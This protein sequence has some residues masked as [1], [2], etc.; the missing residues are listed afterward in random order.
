[1]T[2]CEISDNDLRRRREKGEEIRDRA[3]RNDVPNKEICHKNNNE[4]NE[5]SNYIASYSKALPHFDINNAR[6]G[7]VNEN[8]YKKLLKAT[9]S[10][11]PDDFE[12]VPLGGSVKLTNPLSG[13]AFDLQGIDCHFLDPEIV[14][15]APKIN[16]AEAAGEMAELY[17]M[18]LCRD[19]HFNDFDTSPLISDAITDL[20]NNNNYSKF[21]VAPYP[22][23][24][25]NIN[26]KSIFRGFT[27]G[28]V[29]GPFVSQFLLKG[30]NDIDRLLS[31]GSIEYVQKEDEGF[32]KYGSL[33]IDQRQWTVIP[34][35][36]YLTNY[37]DFLNSQ[38]GIKPPRSETDSC[39]N[40]YDIQARRF[41]RNMRDMANYVHFDDL[42]Q[43]FLNACLLLLHMEVPCNNPQMTFDNDNPYG[44]YRK[45]VGFGT[46][47]PPHFLTIVAEVTTRA[48][49]VCWFYKW[50]IHRRLRAEALGGLIHRQLN[51]QVSPPP[52]PPNTYDIHPEILNKTGA[53]QILKRI[54]D[55][56]GSYLLPQA[57]PEGAPTHPSYAAGH[58][59]IAGACVTILK[60]FFDGGF[61]I[62]NPV[63]SNSDGTS[64]IDYTGSDKNDLTVEGELN[65][66]ASNI[67]LGR[68][69][70]GVHY[71]SDH[72]QSLLLGEEIAISILKDQKNTYREEYCLKLRK[73][74][75]DLIEIGNNC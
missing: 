27:E 36:D 11:K 19:I 70:A 41:I 18:A 66:L 33:R 62:K 24:G 75:G 8:A 7:E 48:L 51:T 44:G 50:T 31:S 74:N 45:Q 43:E 64:L 52:L 14:P 68:N 59:T 16:S 34:N 25:T 3:K 40:N 71:R 61:K 65:K 4:E 37:Q 73:F 22:P 38:N 46:F 69:M 17:W 26:T 2:K 53:G 29:K 28:D 57:F 47:G 23:Q 5:Y 49:K 63:M 42:P 39:G 12:D 10:G 35:R 54:H 60:A 21:P 32:I 56:Y 30:S 20:T 58:A 13:Y 6:A 55:K 9:R 15:P 1:M 72:T 67:S